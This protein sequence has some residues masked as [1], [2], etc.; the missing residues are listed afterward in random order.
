[1]YQRQ[2]FTT[3]A[4]ILNYRAT[5]TP[6]ETAYTFLEYQKNGVIPHTLSYSHLYKAA[7]N[8]ASWLNRENGFGER[9]VLLYPPSLDYIIALFACFLAGVLAVPSYPPLSSRSFSQFLSIAQDARPRFILTTTSVAGL[10]RNRLPESL[11]PGPVRWMTDGTQLEASNAFIPTPHTTAFIQYTSG[12]TTHPRGVIVNHENL[13]HNLSLIQTCFQHT[14]E[15][16]GV[17]WLPP[18]HDMGLIGGILQPLYVGF[19]VILMSPFDFL[20]RPLRWLEAISKYQATTSGGPDFAYRLCIDRINPEQICKLD[21][22]S[23]KLAFNGA[24]PVRPDTLQRFAATFSAGGFSYRA[25]YPCYGL[26]ESTLIVTGGAKNNLPTV[27]TFTKQELLSNRVTEPQPI[28]FETLHQR[29]VG[30]GHVLPHG[31]IWIVDPESNI[32]CP[33]GHIGEIWVRSPSVATGYWNNDQETHHTF[34]AH[35]HDNHAGPFLRTGDLGFFYQGELFITGRIKETIIINGKNYYPIDIELT[36]E[37]SHPSLRKGCNAAFTVEQDNESAIVLIQEINPAGD[38]Q[39]DYAEVI[40][41]IRRVVAQCHEIPLYEVVLV[42]KQTVPKTS[43]GKI[44]RNACRE[45][46]LSRTLETVFRETS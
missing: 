9:A 7:R 20:K 6:S 15:S 43:S 23:W 30:C 3:L 1:M 10:I 29:L 12:S 11:G 33:P 17:I 28:F 39:M 40:K 27:K 37:S 16:L 32:P 24:E 2:G 45:Q 42:K 13:I 46:Y 22:H 31:E 38:E 44:Q 4:D 18:Y 19:P 41:A 36:A 8:I 5:V 25:F 14:P 34:A 35:I 26:A 21:L